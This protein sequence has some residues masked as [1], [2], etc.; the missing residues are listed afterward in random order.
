MRYTKRYSLCKLHG[1]VYIG[2]GPSGSSGVVTQAAEKIAEAPPT[3]HELIVAAARKLFVTEGFGAISMD[4]I[5]AEAGVSKRTVYS[6][7]ADKGSLFAEVMGDI[8]RE[9]GGPDLGEAPPT[10]APDAVLKAVGHMLLAR[11]L[12][13]QG[14]ALLRTVVAESAQFPEVGK[15]FWGAGPN[16]VKEYLAA[17][18]TELDRRGVVV[19][20]DADLAA[21]NFIGTVTGPYL[22]PQLLGVDPP[23]TDAELERTIGHAVATTLDGIKPR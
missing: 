18:F 23:P 17:Y 3:K 10:D 4:A 13:D 2:D 20:P 15:T 5:A 11:I 1:A 16:R 14:R 19:V 22:L 6:H 9:F 21:L 12:S 8:C 7:F